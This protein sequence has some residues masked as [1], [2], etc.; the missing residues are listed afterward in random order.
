MG[1]SFDGYK[2]LPNYHAVTFQLPVKRILTK[3]IALM[4]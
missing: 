3:L 1:T 4:H 2:N